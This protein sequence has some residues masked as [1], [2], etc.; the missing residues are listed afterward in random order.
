MK[1]LLFIVFPLI[2]FSC[3]QQSNKPLTEEQKGKIIEEIRPLVTQLWA[4]NEQLNYEKWL[5]LYWNSKDFIL[6]VNGQISGYSEIEGYKEVWKLLE[7]QKYN[8]LI[9]KFDVISHDAVVYTMQGKASSKYKTGE[10]YSTDFYA[11][12]ALFRKVDGIWKIVY[13]HGSFPTP[14][15]TSQEN[16]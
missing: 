15:M 13:G 14:K 9:E 7:Y 6:I 5:E 10:I 11:I 4:S 3:G 8:I 12:S 16:T 2:L 1:K